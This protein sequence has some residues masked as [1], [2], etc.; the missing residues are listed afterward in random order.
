MAILAGIDEAGF[1]PLLGPLVVSASVFSVEPGLLDADLWQTFRRSV[2]NSRKHL[3][4]RLLITDSKKAF[5]RA[6]GLGHLERTSLAVLQSLGKEPGHLSGLLAELPYPEL[7]I[8]DAPGAY[9]Q[10]GFPGLIFLGKLGTLQVLEPVVHGVATQ[11]FDALVGNDQALEPWLGEA[12]AS[13]AMV[14]YIEE[15]RGRG[16]ATGVLS[17]Y[18]NQLRQS[19]ILEHPIGLTRE[20]CGSDYNY[21]LLL[22]R[23]GPLFL[24]ALR[25][26]M[27]DTGSVCIP[28]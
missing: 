20:A 24:D 25:R 2:G 15:Y 18:R 13:Y 3:A 6:R 5:N 1:G 17:T 11:W 4:G 16:R 26:E 23:K 19:D 27:G 14:L 9:E 28:D 10:R 21:Q 22:Q 12:A 8:V 7:D